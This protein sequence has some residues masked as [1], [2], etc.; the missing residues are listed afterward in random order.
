MNTNRKVLIKN[1][2]NSLSA[3]DVK[4]HI[5]NENEDV[6][7]LDFRSALEFKKNHLKSSVFIGFDGDFISIVHSLI[8]NINQNI[9]L[10]CPLGKEEEVAAQLIK[11]GY[12]NI[13]GYLNEGMDFLLFNSYE[14]TFINTLNSSENSLLSK[15][16]FIDVRETNDYTI[17]HV[18]NALNIPLITINDKLSD[19][20]KNSTYFI[21]DTKGYHSLIA[22]SILQKNGL[23]KVFTVNGGFSDILNSRIP[24]YEC[25]KNCPTCACSEQ[26]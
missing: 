2:L 21:Y 4:N 7:I 19:L 14:T 17:N 22:A 1:K 25:R 10:I 18:K 24:L 16:L 11:I 20:D 3:S 8:K 9:I 12:K 26:N 13:L 5:A 6:L 15:G 23:T